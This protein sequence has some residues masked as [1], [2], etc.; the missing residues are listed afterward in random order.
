[1]NTIINKNNVDFDKIY[2]FGK[3]DE[4]CFGKFEFNR[5][6]R[7]SHIKEIAKGILNESGMENFPPIVVDASTMNILDGQHRYEAVKQLWEQGYDYTIPVIFKDLAGWSEDEEKF[8]IVTLNNNSKGWGNTD[9]AGSLSKL[10]NEAVATL[11]DFAATHLLCHNELKSGKVGKLKLRYAGAFIKGRNVDVLIKKEGNDFTITDKELENA[12]AC[13][14][15][16]EAL[17]P[18]LHRRMNSWFEQM[19]NAWFRVRKETRII[20]AIKSVGGMEAFLGYL[21]EYIT[22][23]WDGK[24]STQTDFETAFK[25]LV[26]DC[27]LDHRILKTA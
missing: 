21:P 11:T 15:E 24:Y 7:A 5:D 26:L 3:M 25:N 19:V 20:N 16:I 13:Y 4:P 14:K 18:C 17:M 27:S 10:G 8:L 6:V 23:E 2:H 22:S 12:E 9:Y 1:M